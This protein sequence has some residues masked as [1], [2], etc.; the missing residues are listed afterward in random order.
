PDEIGLAETASH[1]NETV[2]NV[3]AQN[4]SEAIQ[5]AALRTQHMNSQTDRPW[6]HINLNLDGLILGILSLILVDS[7]SKCFEIIPIK[8]VT[9]GTVITE[10]VR[11]WLLAY[12]QLLCPGM[13]S[14]IPVCL[15]FTLHIR[16]WMSK[17]VTV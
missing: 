10:T 7:Y 9:T 4:T 14:M 8:S 15:I 3:L 12:Q 16:S 17:S 5:T 2:S 11:Y 1:S 13:S 6:S